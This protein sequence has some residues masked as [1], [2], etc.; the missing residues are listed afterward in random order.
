MACYA[1]SQLEIRV[2]NFRF[3]SIPFR[4]A[5]SN[6]ILGRVTSVS[7]DLYCKALTNPILP[8]RD[9]LCQPFT[10]LFPT[11]F[12][13]IPC[14]Y[15]NLFSIQPS[16]KQIPA[17]KLYGIVFRCRILKPDHTK[18]SDLAEGLFRTA[19]ERF[20]LQSGGTPHIYRQSIRFAV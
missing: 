11:G 15:E 12:R 5:S 3:G 19:P 17:H 16:R 9:L 4:P 1:M 10:V 6:D 20:F 2:R 13:A 8:F 7:C 14:F 18:I